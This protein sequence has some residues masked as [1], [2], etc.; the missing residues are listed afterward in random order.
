M[1]YSLYQYLWF[2]II[3]SFLGWW[4]EVSFQ[5]IKLKKFVNRGFLNGPLTPIYGFGMTILLY[6]LTPL[7]NKVFLLFLGAVF[8]TSLLEFLTGFLLEK[9]FHDKWWDYSELPF[10]IK[11]YIAL[12]FS[13]AW[14][15]GAVFIIKVIHPIIVRLVSFLENP[16]GE[17][18]LILLIFYFLADF[19]IT[20]LAILKIKERFTLLDKMAQ[21]LE[22]YSDEI[23]IE[24]YKKTDLI[25]KTINQK[26]NEH[27]KSKKMDLTELNK[28]QAKI[29]EKKSY[30]HKR[31]EKAYPNLKKR[32]KNLGD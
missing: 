27:R 19:F 18:L 13:I 28:M 7:R 23:G 6:F 15:L 11:G 30:V 8:L 10:N 4:L 32:L 16:I 1:T 20:L 24:I 5:T 14:G 9:F 2:F 12:P 26:L 29:K 3:Y 31:I 22:L 17:I 25:L 21:Q